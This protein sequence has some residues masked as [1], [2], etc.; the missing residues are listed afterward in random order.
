MKWNGCGQPGSK[1]R[2]ENQLA[3]LPAAL[4]LVMLTLLWTACGGGSSASNTPPSGPAASLS[5]T[6]LS[7]GNQFVGIQ[8]T[9]V[10]I[11]LTNT[12]GM[13][14]TISSIAVSGA[15]SSEFVQ[16]NSCGTSLAAG[17]NC[18]INVAFTASAT[19]T[20]TATLSVTDDA[21]GSPQ[22]VTLTGAG[23]T[24]AP[25]GIASGVQ[26]QCSSVAGGDG[27]EPG[28]ICYNVT[29]S[30]CP[31]I[32]DQVAGVKV[33]N[34]TGTRGT[35]TFLVGGGGGP[36]WYDQNFTFGQLTV[37]QIVQAGFTTAQINFYAAPTGF[38]PGGVFAGWLTGPGGVRALSCRFS[39][40][41]KWIHDTIRQANQPFCHTGNSGGAATP[42]YALAY[43]GFD[44]LYNFVEPTSGPPFTRIDK[45]CIC[46]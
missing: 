3:W 16:T 18:T 4:S 12:G 15:N 20:R 21:A 5:V 6:S 45:G 26:A 9:P 8:H 32:A 29:V 28:G 25:I 38:P 19:G 27:G 10:P 30:G 44:T 46:Q 17:A 23:V 42:F 40:V 31:G 39:T 1:M 11:T 14:L 24:P 43:H 41:S 22:S 13:A 7:I 35:V 2:Y 34:P 36:E 33:N 37:D